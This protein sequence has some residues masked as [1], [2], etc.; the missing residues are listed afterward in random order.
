ML[1]DMSE[2]DGGSSLAFCET[3]EGQHLEVKYISQTVQKSGRFF[4]D[5]SCF[6]ESSGEGA[7]FDHQMPDFPEG[8]RVGS[9]RNSHGVSHPRLFLNDFTAFFLEP[10]KVTKFAE[11]CQRCC[12]SP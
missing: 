9:R 4:F 8:R 10:G 12:D 7:T 1:S 2:V 11:V 6:S 5:A 3:T